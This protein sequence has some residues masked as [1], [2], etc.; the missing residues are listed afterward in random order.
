[1]K[2]AR[3]TAII[4][5]PEGRVTKYGNPKL[6]LEQAQFFVDGY[7]EALHF[8]HEGV[9]AQALFN[10]EGLMKGMEPNITASTIVGRP[11]VGPVI[12]LTG[13]KRWT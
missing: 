12:I 5:S 13:K 3:D 10:E 2:L 4:I 9:R 11:L 7:V 1:M 6:T 8:E